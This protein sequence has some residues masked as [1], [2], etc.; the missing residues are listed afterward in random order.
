MFFYHIKQWLNVPYLLALLASACFL[1]SCSLVG[2]EG[3]SSTRA[4]QAKRNTIANPATGVMVEPFTPEKEAQTS[5]AIDLHS[6]Y[7]VELTWD[8][9]AEPVE[10]FII[11]SGSSENS[12]NSELHVSIS[13]LQVIEGNKYRYIIKPFEAGAVV[14][15][16]LAAINQGAV[17][18]R[19]PVQK[20]QA[21]DRQVPNFTLTN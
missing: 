6:E 20:I 16:S 14:Y 9:P 7:G 5:L 4:E 21:E 18:E 1:I 11:Y 3:S 12:L 13:D 2:H 15:V 19:S 10:A 17:S 8:I